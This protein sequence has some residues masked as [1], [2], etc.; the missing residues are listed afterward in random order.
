MTVFYVR[1]GGNR[2]VVIG[3]VELDFTGFDVFIVRLVFYFGIAVVAPRASHSFATAQK[4][5]QKRPPPRLRPCMKTQGFP[6]R[7]LYYHAAPELAKNAQ[8]AVTENSR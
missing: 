4:S 5:N 7:C 1:F 3:Y 6:F 8:T 2:I